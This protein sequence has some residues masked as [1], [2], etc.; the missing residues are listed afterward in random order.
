[1]GHNSLSPETVYFSSE[2]KTLHE[3]CDNLIAFPPGHFYDSQTK[4][5]ERYYYPTWWN[6]DREIVHR[7]PVTYTVLRESLEVAVKK[8]LMSEVPYGVLLSGGLDSSLIAAIAARAT[9]KMAEQ[10]EAVRIERRLAL[11]EGR[12]P[13][14]IACPSVSKHVQPIHR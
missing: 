6:S 9:D 13:G 1:M 12:D 3:E 10:Q 8:R 14:A 7:N 5:V 4:K 11:S 2:L